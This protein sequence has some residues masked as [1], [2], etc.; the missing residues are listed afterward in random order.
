MINA[1]NAINAAASSSAGVTGTIG[2][3][4]TSDSSS[5]IGQLGNT[6]GKDAFL[7]L[8]VAQLKYQDPSKPA[9]ASQFMAETAQFTLVEKFD[10]LAASNTAMLNATQVQAATSMVGK[11]V[12]WTDASGKAAKGVVSS[13]AINNG[14]PSLRVGELDVALSSVTEV[15]AASTT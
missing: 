7:K 9:D 13:V 6:L 14:V 15:K 12:T 2:Q 5:S 11:Q 8:L 10:A 4:G 3:T 1:I